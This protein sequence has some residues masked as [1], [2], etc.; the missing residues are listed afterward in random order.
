[1]CWIKNHNVQK[2]TDAHFTLFLKYMPLISQGFGRAPNTD[3]NHS[4]NITEI[5]NGRQCN[6]RRRHSNNG[7]EVLLEST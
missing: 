3:N 5:N 1:M 6:I 4:T 2:A 7:L